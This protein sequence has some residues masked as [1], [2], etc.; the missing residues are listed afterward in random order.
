MGRAIGL[1]EE[2]LPNNPGE[3]IVERLMELVKSGAKHAP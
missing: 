1:T 2:Q 3:L